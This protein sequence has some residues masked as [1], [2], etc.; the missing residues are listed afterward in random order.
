MTSGL[1]GPFARDH[2]CTAFLSTGGR[3]ERAAAA[4]GEHDADVAGEDD[5]M[6]GELKLQSSSSSSSS[7]WSPS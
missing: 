2:A 4:A 7:S 3:E 5:C 1:H 6:L